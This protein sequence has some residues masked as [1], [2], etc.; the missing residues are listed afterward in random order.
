M[1]ANDEIASALTTGQLAIESSL[2]SPLGATRKVLI[3]LQEKLT[4]LILDS[5]E[6]SDGRRR[7][8]QALLRN[9]NAAIDVSI[10]DNKEI[11]NS[12]LGAVAESA[13]EHVTDAITDQFV[14]WQPLG[15]NAAELAAV[16][17]GIKVNGVST[18]SWWV[19]ESDATKRK[20]DEKISL[21]ILS[22]ETNAQLVRAVRGTKAEGYNDGIMKATRRHTEMIVR[23]TTQ[24]ALNQA[25]LATYEKNTDII[26][27]VRHSSTL[28]GRTSPICVARS[29]L[30]YDI[31]DGSYV[32]RDH[33]VP[34]LSGAPYHPNCRSTMAPI[35]KS[36]AE[37]ST[38][39]DPKVIAKLEKFKPGPSTKASMDGQVP[40]DLTFKQW[41]D[42]KPKGFLDGLIGPGK[43]EL[44]ASGKAKLS[45]ILD[46][47]G[48]VR[49]VEQ[50]KAF[51]VTK[52]AERAKAKAR[53][54]ALA[55]SKIE[56]SRIA[57]GTSAKA[58]AAAPS[59]TE[60]FDHWKK[61]AGKTGVRGSIKWEQA[62]LDE[63]LGFKVV[64]ID[65]EQLRSEHLFKSLDQGKMDELLKANPAKKVSLEMP[66][67]SLTAE[68]LLSIEAGQHRT[69]L[70]SYRGETK[71]LASVEDSSAIL[72]KIAS[73]K[74][75]Q[76]KLKSGVK[77]PAHPLG[78]EDMIEFFHGTPIQTSAAW[79]SL[80]GKIGSKRKL[81]KAL[82]E[83]ERIHLETFSA[84]PRMGQDVP[85]QFRGMYKKSQQAL[86]PDQAA[87]MAFDAGFIDS[88][89]V[90]KLWAQT[91]Q[92]AEERTS[93]SKKILRSRAAE[94]IAEQEAIG[95]TLDIAQK[96]FQERLV[97][98]D[99]K[100]KGKIFL[101]KDLIDLG[102]I[103]QADGELFTV[104]EKDRAGGLVLKDG[105]K[106]AEVY[107]D[108]GAVIRADA[109]LTDS[110]L[111]FAP[112]QDLATEAIAELKAELSRD[113]DALINEAAEMARLR[114]ELGSGPLDS[115]LSAT[116]NQIN[117]ELDKIEKELRSLDAGN[118]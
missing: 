104:L 81:G 46:S 91:L 94:E 73:R 85:S 37:L 102:D 12:E 16:S 108:P 111:Q 42:S 82:T 13:A 50:L 1:G 88:P 55:V 70:A 92:D 100:T 43:A 105:K 20:F 27:A 38:S 44:V 65:V 114:K 14:G 11:S 21:G 4:A 98:T 41:V 62:S 18:D 24:S 61:K 115:R 72:Q 96:R 67:V 8:L 103:V 76:K 31:V 83:Q 51:S 35:T 118:Q 80:N 84:Q 71:I 95:N 116:N 107:L 113:R 34:F 75:V 6:L 87:Q 93:L 59:K 39:K 26:A 56:S 19:T 53:A 54:K 23:T 89:T 28:D 40:A 101:S 86:A 63:K 99:A 77:L 36:W 3:A 64:E 10:R 68:G 60:S 17:G 22:G 52:S 78:R 7:D 106:Y 117:S 33:G 69:L 110:R 47:N 25:R 2:A 79:Q 57:D 97:G 30:V 49:S 9:A 48:Q 58:I 109:W 112:P 32:P 5:P 66:R 29:G 74:A 15:L 45:D 90:D